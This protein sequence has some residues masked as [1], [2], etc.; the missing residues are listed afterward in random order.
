[1]AEPEF[2]KAVTDVLA[3]RSRQV[4]KGF[5]AEHDDDHDGGELAWNA[6]LVVGAVDDVTLPD[7]SRLDD[8]GIIGKW[9]GKPRRLLVIAAA[10]L[11]AEI[12]RL[13]RVTL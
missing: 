9:C 5:D 2:T 6:T 7:V 12:E 10:L 13:D 4:E 3:E 1:M 11:I 8:W